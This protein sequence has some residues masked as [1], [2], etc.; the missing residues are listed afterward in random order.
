MICKV[1]DAYE[2]EHLSNF[3]VYEVEHITKQGGMCVIEVSFSHSP[4]WFHGLK[5]R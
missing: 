3:L 4:G 5:V 2:G 1:I